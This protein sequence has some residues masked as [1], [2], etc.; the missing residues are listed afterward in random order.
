MANP[1]PWWRGG[2]PWF[3]TDYVGVSDEETGDRPTIVT[4]KYHTVS[5]ISW[6]SLFAYF[7]SDVLF[8]LHLLV[9]RELTSAA[10]SLSLVDFL[11]HYYVG[12]GNPGA[13]RCTQFKDTE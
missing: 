12:A 10:G 6:F 4:P 5:E 9:N 13:F 1:R 7:A 2:K 8:F 3:E 11:L